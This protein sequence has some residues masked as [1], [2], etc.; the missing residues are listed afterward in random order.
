[1]KKIV[2][3]NRSW[4]MVG[5]VEIDG[6]FYLVSDG[7]VIR[8]WGTTAGLGELAMKGKLP[9]T[10]LDPL[11]LTKIHKDQVIFTIDCDEEKWKN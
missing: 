5:D 7:A 9:E 3:L 6:D 2:V 11:P 8:R 4:N 1:M 10:I